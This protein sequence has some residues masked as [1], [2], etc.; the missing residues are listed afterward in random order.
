MELLRITRQIHCKAVEQRATLIHIRQ[1]NRDWGTSYSRPPIDPY[2]TSPSPVTKSWRRHCRCVPRSSVECTASR[3]RRRAGTA[4]STRR[5]RRRDRRTGGRTAPPEARRERS[6][7]RGSTSTSTACTPIPAHTHTHTHTRARLT[8][9]FPGLSGWA[10]TRKVKPIWILLKQ[11]TVSGSGI[12]RAVCKSA[13]RSRQ[14]T[15]PTPHHS[16]IYM[17]DALPAAQPTAPKQ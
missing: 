17:P 4:R 7:C 1:Y 8:A 3:C 5:D 6:T 15:T 16:F 13:P 12:S 9:L 10:G 11:G 2:L 14:I